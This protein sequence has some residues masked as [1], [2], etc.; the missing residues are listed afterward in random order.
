MA[1]A[2]VPL[3][4]MAAGDPGTFVL[5]EMLPATFPAA[6]GANTALNAML[7]FGANVCG[8]KPV[9]LKPVPVTLSD[10]T[11]RFAV[12][13]FFTV[14]VCELL[15][16]SI[17]LPKLTLDGVIDMAGLAPV[18]LRAIAVDDGVKFVETEMLPETFPGVVG[19]KTALKLMLVP[20]VRV[21]ALKP[22]T[23]KAVPVTLS[24]E[25]TRFAVPVLVNVI[26]C[27]ELVPSVIVPKFTLEGATEMPAWV[28]VPAKE[29]VTGVPE[30]FVTIEMAP[31]TPPEDAGSK[32]A[33]NVMLALGGS[34]CAAKA[35]TPKPV[36]VTLS[37]ET[38]RFAVPVFFKTIA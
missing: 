34:V 27:V 29:T 20:G 15:V 14:I 4:A 12:P 38:T 33:L 21:F 17:T 1:A 23:L 18:P 7:P 11:T 6:E 35:V 19:A 37:D 2:P 26:A 28:P 3:S 22:V 25:T 16:P 9:T 30:R 13:V 24:D 5:R 32:T 36:P 8:A 10:E 31:E